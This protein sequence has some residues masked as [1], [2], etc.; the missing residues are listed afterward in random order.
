MRFILVLLVVGVTVGVVH[1]VHDRRANGVEWVTPTNSDV[2][3]ALA[4]D[5]PHHWGTDELPAVEIGDALRDTAR[6][7]SGELSTR[8]YDAAREVLVVGRVEPATAAR[9]DVLCRTAT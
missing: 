5:Q 7:A 9:I 3:A 1:V 2:C 4:E 6:Y 8:L